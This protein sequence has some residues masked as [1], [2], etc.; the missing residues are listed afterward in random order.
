MYRPLKPAL[1]AFAGAI[2]LTG[3]ESTSGLDIQPNKNVREDAKGQSI[4]P[5]ADEPTRLGGGDLFSL[6]TGKDDE[7]KGVQLPVN[8]Y[9]WRSTLDTLAFLPLASTDPYG[10]VIVT[11]WGAAPDAPAE[12]FKVTAYITSAELKPQSLRVVINRQ[13]KDTS[14]EWVSAP[15]AEESPRKLEDA[16]LTRARQIKVSEGEGG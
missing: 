16:I 6:G 1:A 5:L 14:G 9:L 3:C 2:L 11:D 13:A 10:G 4:S 12:R 8:K 15:V 7:G